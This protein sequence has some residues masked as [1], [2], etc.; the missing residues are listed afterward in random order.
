M[1][2]YL[3]VDDLSN[4]TST[5]QQVQMELLLSILSKMTHRTK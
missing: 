1:V 4:I 3:E 5:L 2:A